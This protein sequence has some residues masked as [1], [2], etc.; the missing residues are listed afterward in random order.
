VIRFGPARLS[1]LPPVPGWPG[2][3]NEP[4]LALEILPGNSAIRP[5]GAPRPDAD[6]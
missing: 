4:I 1:H 6:H 5:A 3:G 2:I